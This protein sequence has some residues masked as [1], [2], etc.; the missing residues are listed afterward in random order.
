MSK[1]IGRL[2]DLGVA[3]EG[4]R[5]TGEVVTNMI[6][7]SNITFDDKV[8]KARSQVGY[9]TINM[10]G[11][12]ALVAL[13]HAEGI[14]DFDL[15]DESFG[16]FLVALLGAVSTGAVSDSAYPHTFS[17]GN[18]NQHPS[19]SLLYEEATIGNLSFRLCMI[20]SLSITIVP[21]DVVKVSV[22]F[23]GRASATGGSSSVAY[24]AEN[25]FL[26]SS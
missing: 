25:K 14:I 8:L 5:G 17:L 13:R 24:I 1:I 26:G 19:L 18:N 11:N 20:E 23:I 15:H 3:V 6:P 22:T 10:E 7:K 2:I 21:D 9:G 16:I 4:T 12:Q